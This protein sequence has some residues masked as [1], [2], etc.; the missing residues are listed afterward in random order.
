LH[1]ATPI[2]P[3]YLQL[4]D[5]NGG[6]EAP[7]FLLAYSSSTQTLE[8][9]DDGVSWTTAP[10]TIAKGVPFRASSGS[11]YHVTSVLTLN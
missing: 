6:T 8:Y 2:S 4:Y 3:S 1:F 9:S 5:E 7:N 11:A 10:T